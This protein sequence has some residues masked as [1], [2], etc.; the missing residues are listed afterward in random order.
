MTRHICG[1]GSKGFRPQLKPEHEQR[2]RSKEEEMNRIPWRFRKLSRVSISFYRGFWKRPI[3]VLLPL[4]WRVSLRCADSAT[5]SSLSKHVISEV[6]P[7]QGR[8]P[9]RAMTAGSCKCVC[10][11][12]YTGTYAKDVTVL[13]KESGASCSDFRCSTLTSSNKCYGPY[14]GHEALAMTS[15]TPKP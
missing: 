7:M 10:V 11:Y 1:I 9:F 4:G 2:M 6:W 8:L 14:L 13:E 12:T 3:G 15:P 5:P